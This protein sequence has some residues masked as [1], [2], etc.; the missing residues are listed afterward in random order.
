MLP[1]IMKDT[2]TISSSCRSGAPWVRLGIVSALLALG[3]C[4][5]SRPVSTDEYS[6]SWS[7]DTGPESRPGILGGNSITLGV[8]KNKDPDSGGGGATLGVNAYLWRS[9]LDVLSF[10]PIISADPFGG[11]IMT[12]WYQ[13]PSAPGERFKVDA[14]ILKRDLRSDSV[15]LSLFRQVQR[16]GVWSDA[17]VDASTGRQLEDKILARAFSYRKQA[18]T[19]DLAQQ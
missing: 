16:N 14:Y 10:M 12:E 13:M 8:S 9:T 2:M 1:K 19:G 4:A 15:H 18:T 11:V 7:Q 6:S 3:A 5:N 17:P